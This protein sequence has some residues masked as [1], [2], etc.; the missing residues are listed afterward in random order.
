VFK[1]PPGGHAG[2]L[3]EAADLK[4]VRLGQ[5]QISDRHANFF[6]NLGGARAS[7]VKGLMD[8]AQRVVWERFQI[9]LEP[10][11]RLVGQW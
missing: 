4:G 10:E 2:R 11:V 6:L 7:E 9:W 1:N 8:L 3:I 5:V